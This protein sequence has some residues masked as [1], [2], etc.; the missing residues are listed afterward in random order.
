[1][2]IGAACICSTVLWHA[3]LRV[4]PALTMGLSWGL[5]WAAVQYQQH[6][7]ELQHTSITT[8]WTCDS[9]D[10]LEFSKAK[11]LKCSSDWGSFRLE[12]NHEQPPDFARPILGTAC[13]YNLSGS[14]WNRW[15]YQQGARGTLTPFIHNKQ[16]RRWPEQTSPR[17]GTWERLNSTF[18][19]EVA[20]LLLAITTGDK[21]RLSDRLKAT[22]SRAGLAHL[23]A[24]SGYHVGLIALISVW[25]LRRK[26]IML[27]FIGLVS[28]LG[29]WKFIGFCGSPDSAIRAGMM[30]TIYAGFQLMYRSVSGMHML[31]LSAWFMLLLAPMRAQQLG[32]Q[33]SFIA[34]ASILLTLELISHRTQAKAAASLAI[35]IAAQAG[36]SFITWP[37]FGL[38]PVHFLLFNLVASPIMIL[39]GFILAIWFLL[40]HTG[41]APL[42]LAQF[43]GAIEHLIASIISWLT[44]ENQD[45]WALDVSQFPACFGWFISCLFF[46]GV[47]MELKG[48]RSWRLPFVLVCCCFIGAV[49]WIWWVRQPVM[50]VGMRHAPYVL[51]QTVCTPLVWNIQDQSAVCKKFKFLCNEPH[52]VR[53]LHPRT[54]WS[55]KEGDWLIRP[56]EMHTIGLIQNRPF[57]MSQMGDSSVSIAFGAD[58]SLAT[59]WGDPVH[60]RRYAF[61]SVEASW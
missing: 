3:R 2:S 56:S 27:R 11:A 54:Y 18:S 36:T 52:Q 25:L 17:A 45:H 22:L 33:L 50:N 20:G 59:A 37:I 28:L 10:I 13:E 9:T 32:T 14:S 40:Q 61:N 21:S 35:P 29:V 51:L 47:G 26:K 15:K 43:S 1:M 16:T 46:L 8:M 19:P 39:L 58:S 6:C 7:T 57:S 34:V 5:G 42:I 44:T 4:L 48:M 38:F 12:W 31:C 49:P 30:L 41:W 24:V 60:F 23:L 53:L 55:N